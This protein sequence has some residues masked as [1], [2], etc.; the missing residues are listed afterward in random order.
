MNF[1]QPK[2]LAAYL[3]YLASNDEAYNQYFQWKEHVKF[4]PELPDFLCNMC[5]DLNLEIPSLGVIRKGVLN[6]LTDFWTVEDCKKPLIESSFNF[7]ETFTRRMRQDSILTYNQLDI[8]AI[9][10]IKSSTKIRVH[11]KV[12]SA[13]EFL[14]KWEIIKDKKKR[15]KMRD[16]NL[17]R[18]D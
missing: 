4:L 17:N 6:N 10:E 14:A 5:I 16:K 9:I 8:E 3:T 11:E 2:A 13:Q 12:L 1:S 7:N 15:R 18:Q